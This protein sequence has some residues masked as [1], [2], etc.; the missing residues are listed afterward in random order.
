MTTPSPMTRS[1]VVEIQERR[2]CS[3]ASAHG[4]TRGRG[5]VK[6]AAIAASLAEW[7]P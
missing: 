2:R 6:N 3:A 7:G 4:N 5:S 1:R